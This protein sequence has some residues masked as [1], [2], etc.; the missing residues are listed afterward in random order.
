M[1]NAT[2]FNLPKIDYIVTI[3]PLIKQSHYPVLTPIAQRLDIGYTLTGW[4]EAM[5]R[6]GAIICEEAVE[7]G[8]ERIGWC[9]DC[10]IRARRRAGG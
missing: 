8:Y 10:R 2:L 3:L 4:K 7:R 9:K 5:T 6:P 1:T